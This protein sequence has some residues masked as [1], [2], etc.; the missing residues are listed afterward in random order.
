MN[1]IMVNIPR[2]RIKMGL[3]NKAYTLGE[4][5]ASSITH[6]IGALLS[7]AALVLLIVFAAIKGTAWHVVSFSIF[8]SMLVIMYIQSTLYHALTNKKAKSVF[9]RLDHISIF[10]LIAG[11]YTPYCLTI[12]RGWLGWTI[13]GIVWGCAI[14]GIVFKAISVEKFKRFSTA[15][16]IIMGWFIILAIRK[17]FLSM[18]T[19]GFI[20]LIVGGIFYTA[21]AYFYS[22]KKIKFNHAIWHVFV[23]GGSVFHFFSVMSLL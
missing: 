16:F 9:R 14:V 18:Q 2:G 22:N 6:G 1:V 3:K 11:T 8:G 15:L 21:G 10:L 13:F 19:T 17:M 5:I 7:I 23:I 20:F 4:E 12:L